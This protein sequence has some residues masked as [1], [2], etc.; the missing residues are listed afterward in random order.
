MPYILFLTFL[1]LAMVFLV[2]ETGLFGFHL[3]ACFDVFYLNLFVL[4]IRARISPVTIFLAAAWFAGLNRVVGTYL[5]IPA[6]AIIP[7]IFIVVPSI[8]ATLF[9][10]EK[11][12]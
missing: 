5:I 4:K 7:I 11:Q 12:E 2:A 10:R 3:K 1:V 6:W 8:F 9:E